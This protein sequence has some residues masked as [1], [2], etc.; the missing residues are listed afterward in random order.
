MPIDT[1]KAA[2][3][4]QEDGTFSPEQ[5]KRIAETLSEMDVASATKEDLNDL[6]EKVATQS[7]LKAVKSDLGK[8]IEE[9]HSATIRTVLGAIVTMGAFLV[10][11]IPL[12]FYLTG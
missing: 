6:E 7:E 4:L 12:A 5:A 2:R 3:R 11:E 10:V 8:Q 1:L 9:K